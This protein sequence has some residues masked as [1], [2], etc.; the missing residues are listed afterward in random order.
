M[1]RNSSFFIEK[2]QRKLTL[3]AD[4]QTKIFFH[5]A[6][7]FYDKTNNFKDSLMRHTLYISNVSVS[8]S[9]KLEKTCILSCGMDLQG[10][11]FQDKKGQSEITAEYNTESFIVSDVKLFNRKHS[12][13]IFIYKLTE[14]MELEGISEIYLCFF[15]FKPFDVVNV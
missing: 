7:G 15:Q 6:I 5:T 1:L 13:T 4:V 11:Y 9:Q 3:I 2:I 12:H 14:F 8:F 10:L